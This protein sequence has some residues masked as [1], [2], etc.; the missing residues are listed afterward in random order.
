M[1]RGLRYHSY[2]KIS[3]G[4]MLVFFALSITP[5][6]VLHHF[7]ANHKD[8]YYLSDAETSHPQIQKKGF[9][10]ECS[11]LVVENPFVDYPDKVYFN[12]PL[13][14]TNINFLHNPAFNSAS[15]L[16]SSLRGPPCVVV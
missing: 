3:A 12:V 16:F 10:C 14:F 13:F 2:K 15:H 4:V 11:N 8:T 7:F 6:Q 5:K 9:N 1:K